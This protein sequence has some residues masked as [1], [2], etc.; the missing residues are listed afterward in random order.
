MSE[1][2]SEATHLV[3]ES[4]TE[5]RRIRLSVGFE[6]DVFIPEIMSIYVIDLSLHNEHQIYPNIFC[7][8]GFHSHPD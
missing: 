1:M 4:D 5:K 3:S 6:F 8:P 7:R 2:I